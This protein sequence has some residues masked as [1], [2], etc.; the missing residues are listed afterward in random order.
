MKYEHVYTYEDQEQYNKLIHEIYQENKRF[1]ILTRGIQASGKSTWAKNLSNELNSKNISCAIVSKDNIRSL[2]NI[3]WSKQ[4]ENI[5][6]DIRNRIIE[7]YINNNIHIIIVDDTNFVEKHYNDISNLVKS[8][9]I[10][11]DVV[12]VDFNTPLEECIERDHNRTNSVGEDVIRKTY[13]NYISKLK[14]EHNVKMK[15]LVDNYKNT[16]DRYIIVDIDG[17]VAIMNNRNPFEWDKVDTDDC[18]FMIR[19]IV[20]SLSKNNN[21]VFVSG[22]DNICRDKTT[23]WI[24][25]HFPNMKFDLLMRSNGDYRPDEIIKREIY[26]RFLS[27]MNCVMV[28]DDRPKVVKMWKS[29]GLFVIDVNQFPLD[30]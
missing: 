23:Q 20:L 19:D 2:S 22:R 27:N 24:N 9:G 8:T 6:I 16:D 28:I 17:T 29:L 25:Q 1:V 5:I 12:F 30:F 15:S 14:K 4:N 3:P 10:N 26:N 7:S 21:I 11:A 13:K 18:N